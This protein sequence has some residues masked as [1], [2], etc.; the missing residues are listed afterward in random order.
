MTAGPAK[1]VAIG[2]KTVGRDHPT[3]VIA[4]IGLNHNGDVAIAKQLIDIAAE[5]GCDAV[6]FQKRTPELCVPPDQR[7]IQREIFTPC[8]HFP[9]FDVMREALLARIQ[10]DRSNFLTRL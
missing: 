9:V 1:T 8:P 3:Y 4:E 5:A 2:D 7:N 10:I 6:K